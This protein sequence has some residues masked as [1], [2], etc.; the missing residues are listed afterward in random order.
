MKMVS[1]IVVKLFFTNPNNILQVKK[2]II[3]SENVDSKFLDKINDNY[4]LDIPLY[5]II[6][7]E[8]KEGKDISKY[9]L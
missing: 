6:E 9:G 2:E 4:N 3:E 8:K 5:K 7:L 1:K